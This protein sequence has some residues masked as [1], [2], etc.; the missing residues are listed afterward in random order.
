MH[1][2]DLEQQFARG[3]AYLDVLALK[4]CRIIVDRKIR[5]RDLRAA[6]NVCVAQLR[7]HRE[8]QARLLPDNTQLRREVCDNEAKIRWDWARLCTM[9]TLCCCPYSAK[10][11]LFYMV[12]PT[13]KLTCHIL[14][15]VAGAS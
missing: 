12:I 6:R 10:Q 8:D 11:R 2:A 13:F 7:K 5:L 4:E 1:I 9:S 3:E 14:Q 15:E